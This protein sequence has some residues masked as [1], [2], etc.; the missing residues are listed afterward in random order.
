MTPEEERRFVVEMREYLRFLDAQP[1]NPW[2]A[3]TIGL[4]DSTLER[5]WT[6]NP[7]MMTPGEPIGYWTTVP[8]R[9]TLR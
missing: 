1:P 7:K 4:I 9:R 6:P 3:E 2:V 8:G 5:K